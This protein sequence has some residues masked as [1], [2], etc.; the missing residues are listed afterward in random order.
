MIERPDQRTAPGLFNRIPA[1]GASAH[2]NARS[3]VHEPD[4]PAR[5]IHA[6]FAMHRALIKAGIVPAPKSARTGRS[7]FRAMAATL[8]AI[9]AIVMAAASRIR[10][11]RHADR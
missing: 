4:C 7:A 11:G 2:L 3:L 10:R 5:H 6:A 9:L 8:G 1:S